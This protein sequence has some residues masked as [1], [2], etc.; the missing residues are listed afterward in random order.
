MNEPT[1]V[2]KGKGVNLLHN[3]YR[4]SKDRKNAAGIQHWKCTV[5]SCSGRA[6]STETDGLQVLKSTDHDHEPD[7]ESTLSAKMKAEL[8]QK[9]AANPTLPMKEVY[10]QYMDSP[11]LPT[12]DDDLLE[13]QLRSCKSQM[14]RA[15]RHNMPHLPPTRDDIIL[16]G[17][18]ATTNDDQP[19]VIHQDN[20][21]ILLGTD[22]NLEMLAAADTI[23]MDGTFKISPRLFTQLFTLHIIYMGFFIPVVYA[24][25]K[26]KSG[27]TY[28]QMFEALRRKMAT[29][30]LIFNPASFML[31]FESGILN[32]LRQH[33]PNTTIK[34]CNFH[35]TQ[36]VWRKVQS[37]GLVTHYKAGIP[38]RIIKSLMALPFVPRIWTRHTFT[39]ITMMNNG[40]LPAIAEL[41]QYFKD[42]WLN[43]QY[44][45][46]MWNM[47]QQD[48]RTN[49]KLEGWHN[50]LNRAVKKSHPNIFELISTLKTEQSATDRIARSARLGTQP[51]P[52]R[53]KTK[54]RQQ[55][56]SNLELELES[57]QRSI[58][59]F[60][61]AMRRHVGFRC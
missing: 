44:P 20:D 47:Y 32:S 8:C 48:T 58:N 15:R 43:G 14:Y 24:L 40:E 1:I 37:L 27:N 59:D 50:A 5:R 23:F 60:L 29:L 10:N 52:V 35:F 51:P 28:Y 7:Y 19:F 36:A 55:K 21:M 4:Y 25:L 11:D 57:G 31:D 41:L 12:L 53:S 6:H 17:Q 34:G 2:K 22:N 39:T 45:I 26:D 54:E 33:F 30:N 61:A 13:P 42:T 3:G 56:I 49:N 16:E 38:R 18:W 9:A 46:A